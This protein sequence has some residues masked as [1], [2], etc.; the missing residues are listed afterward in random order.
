MD[1]ER[2]I[3]RIEAAAR[4]GAKAGIQ[5]SLKGNLKKGNSI[6]GAMAIKVIVFAIVIVAALVVVKKV[7]PFSDLKDQFSK[8]ED[9]EGHDMT[10]ENNGFLGY[11]V[12]DFSEVILGDSSQLKKLEVYSQDM[13]QVVELTEAGLG[14]IKAFTK[15]KFYTYHGTA[16]Y[17]VDLG[18][19]DKD[20]IELDEENQMVILKI[21]HAKYEINIP[22]DKMEIGDTQKGLLAFGE[23]SANDEESQ[24]LY[25]EAKKHMETKLEEDNIQEKA[26]RMAKLSVW[27]IYQP[28]IT[29]VAKG[30][31]LEVQ[32]VE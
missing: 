26:D 25:A 3:E 2:L 10:L 5:E 27:E 4:E 30:Y 9:V 23:L 32:F 15:S 29:G 12:A 8:E 28:L 11:T 24:K 31:V 22:L 14:K 6:F 13:S 21:P 19:L 20:S 17:T 18:E 1:D 7:L 16:I